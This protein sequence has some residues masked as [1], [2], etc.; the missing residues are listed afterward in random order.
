M[1][2]EWGAAHGNT[3]GNVGGYLAAVDAGWPH[4]GLGDD[5]N[6]AAKHVFSVERIEGVVRVGGIEVV[7]GARG[8]DEFNGAANE[9]VGGGLHV[10]A[11]PEGTGRERERVRA[12]GVEADGAPRF[13]FVADLRETVFGERLG[14]VAGFEAKGVAVVEATLGEA[15]T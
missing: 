7:G 5:A 8:G 11:V 10:A 3:L 1:G 15:P 6:V 12:V 9:F 4:S 14:G 2:K 13:E